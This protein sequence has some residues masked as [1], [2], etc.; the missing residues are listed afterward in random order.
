MPLLQRCEHA[1]AQEIKRIQLDDPDEKEETDEMEVSDDE[2]V[3]AK[4]FK[5]GGQATDAL[6]VGGG[7]GG[8]GGANP[9]GA[10]D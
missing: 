10:I 3:V 1:D 5:K 2:S 7:G 6:K 4:R 8:R 9:S